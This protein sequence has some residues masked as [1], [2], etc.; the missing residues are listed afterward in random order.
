[1]NVAIKH[2][3]SLRRIVLIEEEEVEEIIVSEGEEGGVHPWDCEREAKLGA[4]SS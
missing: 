3:M 2:Q 4:C 1:M